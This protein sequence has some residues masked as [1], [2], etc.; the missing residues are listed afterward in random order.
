[1]VP[2]TM[3]PPLPEVVVVEESE[4]IVLNS[5]IVV[6]AKETDGVELNPEAILELVEPVWALVASVMLVP[7]C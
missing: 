4:V 2:L 5:E 3:P 6:V 7:S 1:M